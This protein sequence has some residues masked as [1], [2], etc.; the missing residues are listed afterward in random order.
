MPARPGGTQD[1]EECGA[2]KMKEYSK[3]AQ[4]KV[5]PPGPGGYATHAPLL[6]RA[7]LLPPRARAGAAP[8]RAAPRKRR[9]RRRA[10]RYVRCGGGAGAQLHQGASPAGRGVGA[11]G[12]GAEPRAQARQPAAGP[13][14]NDHAPAARR[15]P[16]ALPTPR[17]ASKGGMMRRNEKNSAP[18]RKSVSV[19]LVK[20][21]TSSLMS[22]CARARDRGAGPRI[23]LL[24]GRN[25]WRRRAR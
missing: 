19:Q 18:V 24:R 15:R 21:T 9:A 22:Q 23:F 5:G 4:G 3:A 10:P 13:A 8:T 7:L 12:R 6:L 14:K 17:P 2:G 25:G 11:A 20:V 1:E 16:P